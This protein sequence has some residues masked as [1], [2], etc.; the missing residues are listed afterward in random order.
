[1]R[2][3]LVTATTG[4]ATATTIAHARDR[5]G[6]RGHVRLYGFTPPHGGA[7]QPSYTG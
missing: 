1:M 5:Y 7:V 3:A 4:K 6:Y 2:L